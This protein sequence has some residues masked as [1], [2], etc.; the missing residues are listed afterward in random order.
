MADGVNFY[1]HKMKTFSPIKNWHKTQKCAKFTP[2][3][4]DFE[5]KFKK[6]NIPE[7]TPARG[8]MT[9]LC[10]GFHL[11]FAKKTDADCKH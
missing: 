9:T 2:K 6:Q 8:G 10:R 4:C 1:L 5:K 11:I 7:E 3:G